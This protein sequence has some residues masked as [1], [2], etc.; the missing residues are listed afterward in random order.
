[1]FGRIG[2]GK[3]CAALIYATSQANVKLLSLESQ[4]ERFPA[5]EEQGPT[6]RRPYITGNSQPPTNTEK[7]RFSGGH[8]IEEQGVRNEWDARDEVC[9]GMYSVDVIEHRLKKIKH[10][11]DSEERENGRRNGGVKEIAKSNDGRPELADCSARRYQMARND[12]KSILV[13]KRGWRF[14]PGR[15]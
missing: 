10:Q 14:R 9:G 15:I 4:I 11:Q 3:F 12:L 8:C 2:V 1:M 13:M 7:Y 5:S 6:F